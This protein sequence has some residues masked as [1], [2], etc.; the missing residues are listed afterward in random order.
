MRAL[1]IPAAGESPIL[2][3]VPTPE[4]SPGKVLIKVKAASLNPID[5]AIAAGMLAQMM[6]HEYPLVLGRD[7]AGV[8]EA[9]GEGVGHVAVGDAVIG[10]E[11]L[12]P[13]VQAGTIA[14]YALLPAETV[15]HKPAGLDFT[16]A[17][18]LPL[19]SAAAAVAIDAVDPQPG[20][21]VLVN[22]ASGG[23]GSYAVQLL[24]ARG[25]TVIAT[26]RPE[27]SERLIRLGAEH[28][29]DY[30]AGDVADKVRTI[31]PNGGDALI[32]LASYTPDS[33][34][35]AALRKG[36]KVASTNS[37][38]DPDTL[39]A[40]GF[41]GANIMGHALREVIAPL[42]AQAA[43][44]DLTIDVQQV[45]AFDDAESGFAELSKGHTAGKLVIQI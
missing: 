16:A 25:V 15:T 24:K 14:E 9:V 27:D 12:V 11:L 28:V 7:A 43:S 31:Y 33:L 41:S 32:D 19:A 26:G 18:A 17:A 22:G 8:V 20:S 30:T 39:S 36:A 35:L 6:P 5:T 1:N 37:A 45:Y 2:S 4:V 42:A 3:E 13:P 23:V 40:Q 29:I 21:T 38:A 44:G 10:H 34:P